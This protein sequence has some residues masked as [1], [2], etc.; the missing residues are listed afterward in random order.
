MYTSTDGVAWSQASLL[1]NSTKHDVAYGQVIG[2]NSSHSAGKVA[3][4]VYAASPATVP[5]AHRDFVARTITFDKLEDGSPDDPSLLVSDGP[6][7][8]DGVLR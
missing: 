2:E 5:G 1:L 7:P 6:L 4:L 8:P 3:T